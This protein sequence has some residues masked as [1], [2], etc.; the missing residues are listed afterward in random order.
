MKKLQDELNRL[1][2]ENLVL[3]QEK[4]ALEVKVSE[5]LGLS[6]VEDP[7]RG[8]KGVATCVET[9]ATLPYLNASTLLGRSGELQ[10][11]GVK[12]EE[13]GERAKVGLQVPT[14]LRPSN[15]NRTKAVRVET[16]E[17][18]Q[19]VADEAAAKAE[20][21]LFNEE[22][23]WRWV[24]DSKSLTD[25]E[26]KVSRL[27]KAWELFALVSTQVEEASKLL[28]S[29]TN[30]P[31]PVEFEE[32]LEKQLSA[33]FD[34]VATDRYR[35][36]KFEEGV[37]LSAETALGFALTGWDESNHLF[38]E[39]AVKGDE[40]ALRKLLTE[41]GLLKTEQDTELAVT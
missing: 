27:E 12:L 10:R 2:Q 40:S 24:R 1:E 41:T 19:E 5:L 14:H 33:Y 37:E 9:V 25:L 17:R 6:G 22:L 31:F 18:W 15:F 34:S 26:H 8:W 21:G 32:R 13:K 7:E 38:A 35:E 29:L 30:K 11:L 36:D 16:A 4:R 23:W 39:L 28:V 20:A 3:K